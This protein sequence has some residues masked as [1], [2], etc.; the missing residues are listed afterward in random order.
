LRP[1]RGRLSCLTLSLFSSPHAPLHPCMSSIIMS[2]KRKLGETKPC[3]SKQ[4]KNKKKTRKKNKINVTGSDKN[5]FNEQGQQKNKEGKGIIEADRD[6]TKTATV[7]AA[8]ASQPAPSRNISKL[9]EQFRDQLSGSRF[10]V[11]NEELYTSSS[12]ETYQKFTANPQL[13]T[14]YHEGYQRQVKMWPVNPVNIISQSIIRATNSSGTNNRPNTPNSSV[15]VADF[16]CGDAA[17]LA[18]QL[19]SYSKKKF[20]VHSFDLVSPTHNPYN[21][22]ACDMAHVPL[23]SN[24]VH[25][26]VFCLSLM[27][28]NCADF[29]REAHRVLTKDGIIKIA[30]V[31]SR[32]EETAKGSTTSYSV[33]NKST[34]S[35]VDRT[36]LN[37]FLSNM[38]R[39]GFHCTYQ[40]YHS[41]PMF[42][43]LDFT[44]ISNH[45]PSTSLNFSLKPCIYKRR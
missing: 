33:D 34:A 15:I 39:L 40:D 4:Q 21:I 38:K 9:Q 14:Q 10:R 23:P 41:N 44:K 11:L 30:E 7:V 13:F 26:A 1:S 8:A 45:R 6:S 5:N 32:L 20:L 43:Y 3:E 42:T 36:L 35:V 37:Q 29:I 2:R 16:G 19:L 12:Q 24:S 31:R 25:I 27:G 17:P 28:V 22:I 18:Q